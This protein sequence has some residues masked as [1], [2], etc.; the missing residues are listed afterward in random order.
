MD[1]ID[2]TPFV[3]SAIDGGELSEA[4]VVKAESILTHIGYV[5]AGRMYAGDVAREIELA[6]PE[7]R[8]IFEAA[9]TNPK[10]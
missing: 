6:D 8:S 2:F 7:V 10:E 5:R 9:L 3:K 4:A 1:D